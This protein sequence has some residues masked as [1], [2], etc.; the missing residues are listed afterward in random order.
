MLETEFLLFLMLQANY[1]S[2][3]ERRISFEQNRN[4]AWTKSCIK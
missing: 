3:N 1:L 4:I 2:L